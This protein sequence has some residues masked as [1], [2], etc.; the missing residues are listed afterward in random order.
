MRAVIV[1]TPI[2]VVLVV[3]VPI[4]VFVVDV[5]VSPSIRVPR[6]KVMSGCDAICVGL[7]G[8]V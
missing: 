5:V 1:T 2:L 8:L 6:D 4:V 7:A 3:I